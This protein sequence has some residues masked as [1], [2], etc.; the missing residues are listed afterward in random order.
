MKKMIE[1]QIVSIIKE[2]EAGIPIKELCR[3]Y[4]MGN[5]TLLLLP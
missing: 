3:K 5:F 4:G 2:A 1:H